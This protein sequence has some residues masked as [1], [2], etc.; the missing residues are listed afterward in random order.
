LPPLDDED[1]PAPLAVN[2]NAID[3]AIQALTPSGAAD[4]LAA[5]QFTGA[6]PSLNADTDNRADFIVL[7]TGTTPSDA[8]T[9]LI[10]SLYVG[11]QIATAVVAIDPDPSA[12][13]AFNDMARA[14]G[15]SR[16][17]VYDSTECGSAQTCDANGFCSQ[18][19]W[20]AANVANELVESQLSII[21]VLLSDPCMIQLGDAPT[22][23]EYVSV[24]VNG[25]TLEAGI[26][27]Y[28]LDGPLVRL[29]GTTCDSVHRATA[30][31]PASI[32]IRAVEKL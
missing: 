8:A 31:H 28:T 7:F 26:D 32:Q 2:A 9:E 13:T 12:L 11:H 27:T 1:L 19:F 29:T 30:L 22:R 20:S 21:N 6:L 25:V 23:P 15:T 5:L 17:C 18:G 10:H 4:T 3:D 14:G 16:R 24:V